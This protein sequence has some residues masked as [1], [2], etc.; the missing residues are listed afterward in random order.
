MYL[1]VY[2]FNDAIRSCHFQ[3]SGESRVSADSV[4]MTISADQTSV[5]SDVSR[6]FCRNNRKISRKEIFLRNSVFIM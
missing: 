4:I 1:F 2:V 6:L 5:Q 3:Q